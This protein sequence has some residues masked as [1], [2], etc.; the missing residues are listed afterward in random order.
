MTSLRPGSKFLPSVIVNSF[1]T[2]NADGCTPRIGTLTSVPVE[3]LGTSTMTNSSADASGP[4][5]PERTPGAS[6][7]IRRLLE[8][9][10]ARELA[11]GAV[12][13]DDH[14]VVAAR[15]RQRRLEADRHRQH[16][17]HHHHDPGDADHGRRRSAQ[18]LRQVAQ[19]E[20][21]DRDDLRQPRAE[22]AH[23][24]VLRSASTI[25]SRIACQA[26]MAPVTKPSATIEHQPQRHGAALDVEVG[27]EPDRRD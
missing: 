12:A 22:A 10:A 1:L 20:P 18:P 25:D 6:A 17:D 24:H 2:A 27:D 19:V 8:P 23:G 9:E 4:S 3:R 15:A 5:S 11:G 16:A 13:Q 14:G 21:G 26:G 7:M